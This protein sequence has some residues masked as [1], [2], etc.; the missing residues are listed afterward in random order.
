[1]LMLNSVAIVMLYTLNLIFS[2]DV[3]D[4]MPYFSLFF[5]KLYNVVNVSLILCVKF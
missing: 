2:K 1:M 4:I 3:V 5:D